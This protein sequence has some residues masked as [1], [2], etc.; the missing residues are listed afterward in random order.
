MVSDKPVDESVTRVTIAICGSR[1]A[2]TDVAVVP[3]PASGG[4]AR[5]MYERAQQADARLRRCIPGQHFDAL[6][7][8]DA[9]QFVEMVRQIVGDRQRVAP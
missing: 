1:A 6:G 8:Q 2:D 4:A 7:C 9:A 5:R 3:F